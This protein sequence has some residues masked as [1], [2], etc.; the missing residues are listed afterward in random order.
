MVMRNKQE[1]ANK[2]DKRLRSGLIYTFDIRAFAG[3]Q[4]GSVVSRR[5]QDTRLSNRLS[6]GYFWT[7]CFATHALTR[8][9]GANNGTS[10]F[11]HDMNAVPEQHHSETQKSQHLI[12]ESC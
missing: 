9:L 8:C 7:S 12:I 2:E 4:G 6:D 10:R 11:D 5:V 3:S 1:K